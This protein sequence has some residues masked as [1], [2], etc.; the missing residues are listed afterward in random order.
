MNQSFL[1][2]QPAT[3]VNHVRL[4][5][6]CRGFF[7]CNISRSRSELRMGIRLRIGST[8]SSGNTIPELSAGDISYCL[9]Y[10][11]TTYLYARVE[12][13]IKL[14]MKT[15]IRTNTHEQSI[16]PDGSKHS[17][18]RPKCPLWSI[19]CLWQLGWYSL[20]KQRSRPQMLR[21]TLRQYPLLSNLFVILL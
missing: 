10:F 11:I 5:H 17:R 20:H 18:N 2:G 14:L 1:P 6:V 12:A 21:H 8:P 9:K 15:V 19:F 4:M 7:L 3:F 16:T 13:M